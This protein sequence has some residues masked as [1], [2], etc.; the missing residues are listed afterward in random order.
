MG[1]VFLYGAASGFALFLILNRL[2]WMVFPMS[3]GPDIVQWMGGPPPVWGA[4]IRAVP[5][6]RVAISVCEHGYGMCPECEA[7]RKGK[8]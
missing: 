7:I 4:P 2:R 6:L 1:E 8:P 3:G 5:P